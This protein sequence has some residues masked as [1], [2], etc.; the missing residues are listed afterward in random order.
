MQSIQ[1]NTTMLISYVR[2]RRV[3]LG[4]KCIDAVSGINLYEALPMFHFKTGYPFAPFI[5]YHSLNSAF[6]YFCT[7]YCFSILLGYD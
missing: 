1:Y 5:I 3:K 4:I 2:K 6:P 7:R